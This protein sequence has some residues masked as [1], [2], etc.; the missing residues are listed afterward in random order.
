MNPIAKE[1]L[2]SSY[3]EL[4][5]G[6]YKIDDFSNELGSVSG[7]LEPNVVG[8]ITKVRIQIPNPSETW[9]IVSEID[10]SQKPVDNRSKLISLIQNSPKVDS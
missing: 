10:F 9:I 8:Q 7:L 4:E 6:F 1:K 3:L 5:D 2:P